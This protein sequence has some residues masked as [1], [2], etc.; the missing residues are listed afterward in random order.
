MTE[1]ELTYLKARELA[2]EHY[3]NF[4]VVSFLIPKYLQNDVA[5]IYWFARTADNI[6]DE[7]EMSEIKRLNLLAEFEKAFLDALAGE[8]DCEFSHALSV[9]IKNRNLTISYFTDLLSAFRQD[10]TIKRYYDFDEVLDYCNRSANPVGRLLLE[11]FNIRDEKAFYFSDKICTALQ[12]TNFYQDTYRDYK[13]GR[14][15]YPQNELEKY[16]IREKMFENRKIN[17]NFRALVKHNVERASSL[18]Y[19]GKNLFSYLNG[20]LKYEIKWTVAGGEEILN[21]IRKNNYNVLYNR[22]SLTKKDFIRI[23]LKSIKN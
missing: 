4:P 16:E 12:L 14:I 2:K 17:D 5:I 8:I 13:K 20:R 9:T 18:F 21:K 1:L 11:L 3:E 22:P 10:V 19:E 6:A 15:Y 7:G 23:L